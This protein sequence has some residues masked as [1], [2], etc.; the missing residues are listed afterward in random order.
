MP[1]VDAS[2]IVAQAKSGR[3]T[4]GLICVAVSAMATSTPPSIT[5]AGTGWIKAPR[6]AAHSTPA[7][8]MVAERQIAGQRD[9]YKLGCHGL[10]PKAG[11]RV[12]GSQTPERLAGLALQI[13]PA[14]ATSHRTLS[15]AANRSDR[16][17]LRCFHVITSDRTGSSNAQHPTADRP[18]DVARLPGRS[19]M[20]CMVVLPVAVD[21]QSSGSR[22]KVP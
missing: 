9:C 19:E 18:F 11:S 7:T 3:Q 10:T 16:C 2:R 1:S 4:A 8:A 22:S 5:G 17:R 12:A 21:G 6:Y 15:G 20:I 13:Q 14:R